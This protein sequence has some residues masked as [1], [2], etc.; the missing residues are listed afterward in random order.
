MLNC[1][2]NLRQGH[3]KSHPRDRHLTCICLIIRNHLYQKLSLLIIAYYYQNRRSWSSFG[4]NSYELYGIG[5]LIFVS[6]CLFRCLEE[7]AEDFL[8]KPVKLAD[9]KRLRDSLMKADERA[10]KNIMH[11]REL[12]AN[13]IYS[14]LKRAK[15]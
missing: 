15:I 4:S 9:V 1:L 2:H 11:K 7:G 13:D 10:F 8:L 5:S 3:Y 6:L 14:Q 12:E